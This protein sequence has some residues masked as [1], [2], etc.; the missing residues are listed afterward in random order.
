[1][2]LACKTCHCVMSF[3]TL[4]CGS[5]LSDRLF[6]RF[7]DFVFNQ[8]GLQNLELSHTIC[9]QKKQEKNKKEKHISGTDLKNVSIY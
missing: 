5:N 3:V 8:P 7:C 1:M 2:S 6:S 4:S 9:K